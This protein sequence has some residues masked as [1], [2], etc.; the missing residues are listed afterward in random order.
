MVT[1]IYSE[2]LIINQ[3]DASPN[4]TVTNIGNSVEGRAMH[5]VVFGPGRDDPNAQADVMFVCSQHGNEPAGREAAL[6]TMWE[7]VNTPPAFLDDLTILWIP[8]ANPDGIAAN[9]RGNS[10]GVDLNRRWVTLQEQENKVIAEVIGQRK[11]LIH[12]DLH[13]YGNNSL[14]NKDVLFQRVDS[15]NGNSALTDV[16]TSCRS[17]L[18]SGAQGRANTAGIYGSSGTASGIVGQYTLLAA[19]QYHHGEGILVESNRR[20]GSFIPSLSFRTQLQV[21]AVDDVITWY[22]TNKAT[23]VAAHETSKADAITRGET[24]VP[25]TFRNGAPS[26]NPV[27]IA[28]RILEGSLEESPIARQFRVFGFETDDY[29]RILAGQHAWPLVA[30]LL[31]PDS[32]DRLTTAFPIYDISQPPD[33]QPSTDLRTLIEE[34]KA[35]VALPSLIAEWNWNRYAEPEVSSVPAEEDSEVEDS[36]L[37]PLES[38][39]EPNRPSK[40]GILKGWPNVSLATEGFLTNPPEF[41]YYVADETDRYKYWLAPI[42]ANNLS[43]GSYYFGDPLIVQ[44]DYKGSISTNKIVIGFNDHLVSPVDFDIQTTIDGE[45]WSTIS[46]DNSIDENGQIVLYLQEGGSWSDV[47]HLSTSPQ[48]VQGLR[49]VVNSLDRP[50]SYLNVIEMSARLV[51]DLTEWVITDSSE[52]EM[53]EVSLVTPLGRASSNTASVVLDNREGHFNND[54][55]SS[56]FYGIIDHN[57]K[58]TMD[59]IYDLDKSGFGTGKESV[60]RFTMYTDD[61]QGQGEEDVT[62]G[63]K[64]YSKFFQEA[65]LEPGLHEEVTLGGLVWTIC[66][67]LG[68]VDYQYDS[69][70]IDP[71]TMIPYFWIDGEKTAW[72]IISELAEA[73]QSAIFFDEYGVLRIQARDFAYNTTKLDGDPDW[74]VSSTKIFDKEPDLINATLDTEYAANRVTVKYQPIRISDDQNGLPKMET[75]WEPEGTVTLRSSN[76]TKNMSEDQTYLYLPADD[77]KVWPYEG[78]L[79]VEGEIIRY[80]GKG[81]YWYRTNGS[82][83]HNTIYSAEDKKKYDDMSSP[84]LKWQNKFSGRL[85][86]LTRGEWNTIARTHEIEATRY[87]KYRFRRKVSTKPFG[88]TAGFKHLRDES[89]VRLKADTDWFK[90]RA[91]VY[92]VRRGSS[93]DEGYTSMGTRIKLSSDPGVSGEAGLIFN[94]D[95]A[96]KN[97]AGYYVCIQRTRVAEKNNRKY[98][99]E[100]ALFSMNKNGVFK[101]FGPNNG[102]GTPIQ[103]PDNTWIDLDVKFGI[104]GSKHE[105]GVIVNGVHRLAAEITDNDWKHDMVGR[106]GLFTRGKTMADFEYLYGIKGVHADMSVEGLD[107]TAFWDRVRGGYMSSWERE[108]IWRWRDATRIVKKKKKKYR[109]RSAQ[110]II[111][112]FGPIVHEVREFDVK[113]DKTPNLHTRIYMTNESQVVIP[114]YLADPFG[115]KFVL[116]NAYRSNAVVNGEDTKTFGSNNP[117]DQKLLIYGRQIYQD[118]EKEHVVEDRNGILRRGIVE[119]EIQNPWIQSEEMAKNVGDWIVRQWGRGCDEVSVEI[120]GN[121]LIKLG[122]LVALNY[123]EKDFQMETHKYFVIRVSNSFDNGLSTTL[124]LRRARQ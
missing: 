113:F 87:N 71:V 83:A 19:S 34:G 18:I 43:S 50:R 108:W 42:T 66:D 37:Y 76:I 123:P 115:A 119:V 26:P 88:W 1:S 64:D 44:I 35:L 107:G 14:T 85:N 31:D 21:D 93:Y 82:R 57:V 53:S 73:T 33:N 39:I 103:I 60:R 124:T 8:T 40:R 11:P 117:V 9:K 105:I 106:F 69:S 118:D 77:A 99:H 4:A 3:L 79:Q 32:P 17:F 109:Q 97:I 104:L 28:Y 98:S 110:A 5:S 59:I 95:S 27:P 70:A 72:Q 13:E 100:V 94:I 84:N 48:I 45:S 74:V 96:Y 80:R 65:Q 120:F 10:N 54:N 16:G 78:M 111:D 81:Y 25:P 102:K 22:Q 68:F 75:V 2:Q 92:V 121:P 89:V 112:E 90:D 15:R 67:S 24:Q 122:D 56:P 29:G 36:D 62:V 38:I 41:R 91:Y 61:W 52:F 86:N 20:S 51:W 47:E 116:A 7:W 63:L 101:R 23:V 46:S 58:F 30:E 114:E 6:H 12:V 55:P 49:M